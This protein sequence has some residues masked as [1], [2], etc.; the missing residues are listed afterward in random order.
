M[1]SIYSP[2]WVTTEDGAMVITT[3]KIQTPKVPDTAGIGDHQLFGSGM[4]QSWN[5][6]CFSGGGIVEFR[7]ALG[8]FVEDPSLPGGGTTVPGLW[9]GLWM[10]GNLGRAEFPEVGGC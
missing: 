1:F 2:E 7:V 10:F 9:P 4:V 3:A 8:G 6:F 5:K